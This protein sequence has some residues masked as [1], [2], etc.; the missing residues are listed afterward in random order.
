MKVTLKYTLFSRPHT[1]E[2]IKQDI[3]TMVLNYEF[4]PMQTYFEGYPLQFSIFH[5]KF[6]EA[7]KTTNRLPAGGT[8]ELDAFVQHAMSCKKWTRPEAE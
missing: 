2:R 6:E 5:T 8:A 1:D 3:A 7:L 4:E